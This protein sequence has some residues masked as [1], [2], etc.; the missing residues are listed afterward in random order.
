[1][2][3]A[4]SEHGLLLL[5]GREAVS[6]CK[7]LRV[8]WE[9]FVAEQRLPEDEMVRP[10]I[11]D[12]WKAAMERGIDPMLLAAPLGA[13]PDEI[14]NILDVDA[15]AQAGRRVL[16][17]VAQPVAQEGHV[18]L[19]TDASGR[20]LYGTGHPGLME[21]LRAAN[22]CPGGIWDESAAGPNGI[23]TAV[24]CRKPVVVFGPEHFC[25]RW[26]RWF[27]FGAPIQNRVTGELLGIVDVTGYA[28]RLRSNQQPLVLSLARAIEYLLGDSLL[29]ERMRLVQAF[30]TALGRHL[31]EPLAVFDRAA[32]LVEATDCWREMT[33]SAEISSRCARAIADVVGMRSSAPEVRVD[34]YDAAADSVVVW[35]VWFSGRMLGAIA[36]LERRSTV[37]ALEDRL[38]RPFAILVG[39][40]PAF[41]KALKMAARAAACT[42]SILITGETGTGK[43]L[44]ARAIHE[45]SKRSAGPM[46][47]VNCAA[48]PRD[49]AESELFGYEG[50][51]FTGARREGKPGRFELADGGTLF[52][53]ELGELPAEVQAKLLRVLEERA[54]LRVGGTRP[55]SVDVRIIAATNRDLLRS[56]A[57]QNGFRRDLFYRLAVIEIDLPP[58]RARGRDVLTLAQAFLDN[59]CRQASRAPLRLSPEVEQCFLSYPW[60]GNVRELRNLAAR[61][62]TLMDS[63][64][65][66]LEDLPQCLRNSMSLLAPNNATPLQ[67]AKEDLIRRTLE[68][69]GGNISATAR[70]LGV[71]RSTI[72]RLLRRR[73]SSLPNAVE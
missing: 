65:V 73:N 56:L 9:R 68:A 36:R 72:Y 43:E 71:D 15:F 2:M 41:R 61:L 70:Q 67:A 55:R 37:R 53:D 4:P 6:W 46:V 40:D 18:L 69:N 50:G 34:L 52:L 13:A 23:G 47:C 59:A 24:N 42:E 33:A 64:L 10:F 3:L 17:D 66:R 29:A 20:I 5:E 1:M 60:P 21:D 35:P 58:L 32:R 12:R 45:S 57:A 62:A 49:L 63:D 14:E 39:D 48:L 51:A 54:V 8:A 44:V 27:C 19:L 25:E 26:Q 38:P 30:Q 31:S 7:Q 16:D 11:L 28:E 22:A